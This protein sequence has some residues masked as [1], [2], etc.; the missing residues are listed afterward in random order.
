M[1]SVEGCDGVDNQTSDAPPCDEELCQIDELR[2]RLA[3]SLTHPC[4][5]PIASYAGQWK[6]LRFLRGYHGNLD[7]AVQ[8]YEAMVNWRAT[9]NILEIREK[10]LELEEST[11][12]MPYPYT[13]PEFKPLVDLI[14]KG[15]M[16]LHGFDKAGN[17][18]TSVNVGEWKVLW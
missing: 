18:I 5:A 4:I 7:D 14:G 12:V 6:L 15:L 8:A 9:N 3:A 17:T 13:L 16:L 1:I 11:G 2:E 10:L